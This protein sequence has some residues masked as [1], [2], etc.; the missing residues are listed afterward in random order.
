[1]VAWHA[2]LAGLDRMSV[3]YLLLAGRSANAR[4]ANQEAINHLER[5]LQLIAGLPE[6]PERT[7]LELRALTM[8]GVPRI[9]LHGYSSAEVE[10]NYRRIVELAERAGDKEQL[11]QGL[12]GLWNCIYDRADLENAK[13]IADRLCDLAVDHPAP[14]ARGLAYRALGGSCLSL[15]RLTEAIAAFESCAASCEGL[16]M[17]AGIHDHGGPLRHRQRLC[18]LRAYCC[19]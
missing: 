6:T 5:A 12:R 14:E 1:M 13:L 19:R 4:Y 11:F 10:A 2:E 16:A 7:A 9:A 8:I 18:R 17:D 3:D 15:G